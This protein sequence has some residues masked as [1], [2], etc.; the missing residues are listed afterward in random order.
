[1]Y[2]AFVESEAE[3]GCSTAHVLEETADNDNVKS[4]SQSTGADGLQDPAIEE[5]QASR[6]LWVNA[7]CAYCS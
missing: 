5:R 1:M 6:R 7:T 3:E 2:A 4:S